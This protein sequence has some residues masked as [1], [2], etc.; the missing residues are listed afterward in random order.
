MVSTPQ[1]QI[2]D[3]EKYYAL[4]KD[5]TALERELDELLKAEHKISD[6]YIRIRSKL[7]AFDT[8]YA[9]T[10][11]QIYELTERKL[12]AVLAENATLKKRLDESNRNDFLSQALNEGDGVYRP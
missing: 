3:T 4:K 7:N 1:K 10:P 8:P 9:P 6:A 5:Y 2:T 11:E 12:D